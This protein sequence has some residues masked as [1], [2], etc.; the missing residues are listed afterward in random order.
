MIKQYDSIIFD[1]DG[2]LWDPMESCLT[3]WNEVLDKLEFINEP[4]TEDV[5][6]N[7]FG[8]KY[9]LIADVLFPTL[10][11]EQKK[12]VMSECILNGNEYLKANGGKL[13]E[14][15]EDILEK[16]SKTHQ[17]FIVSNCQSGYIESFLTYYKLDSYFKD[18]ECPGNTGL[19]KAENIK[20]IIERNKLKSPIYIGDTEGDY[21]ATKANQLPFYFAKYGFGEVEN[22]DII[23]L[24]SLSDLLNEE[25]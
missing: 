10:T 5:M 9:D 22:E 25:K 21:Q 3:S 20:L 24:E 17:L 18:F 7:I 4:I 23:I 8:M 16:L 1:L 13:Y 11:D 19:S 14:P 2:T 12:Q 15:L 6:K